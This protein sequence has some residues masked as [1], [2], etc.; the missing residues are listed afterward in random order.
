MDESSEKNVAVQE[1]G[2]YPSAVP[3]RASNLHAAGIDLYCG[4]TNLSKWTTCTT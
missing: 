3:Y 1:L 4:P 2:S